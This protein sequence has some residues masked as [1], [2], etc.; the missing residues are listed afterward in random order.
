[1][2]GEDGKQLGIVELSQALEESNRSGLDL[3]EVSP[4]AKPPVCRVLDYAKFRYDRQK[5]ARDARKHQKGGVVKEIR[6]RLKTA[7][8]DRE[9][10]LKRVKKFLKEGN[11]VKINIL[12]RGREM[13]YADTAKEIMLKIAGEFS[14]EAVCEMEPSLDGRRMYMLLVPKGGKK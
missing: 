11:K 3:V 7:E 6:F 12:F 4:E 13:I 2:I 1:M 14:S 5:K 10:K 8:H 9:T